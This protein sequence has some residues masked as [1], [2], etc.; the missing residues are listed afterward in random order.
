MNEYDDDECR[1]VVC[2]DGKGCINKVTRGNSMGEGG[3]E[4]GVEECLDGG[5]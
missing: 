2:N 5:G 3:R 1:N 4:D